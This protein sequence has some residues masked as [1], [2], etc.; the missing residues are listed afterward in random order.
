MRNVEQLQHELSKKTNE[1]E[2]LLVLYKY[3]RPENVS[4]LFRLKR[5]I[6]QLF[7]EKSVLTELLK[8]NS[9]RGLSL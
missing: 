4:D 7:K 3:S 1:Y 8:S 5:N 2:D 6:V 9:M